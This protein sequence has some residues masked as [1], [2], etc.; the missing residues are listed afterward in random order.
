[1]FQKYHEDKI[2]KKVDI[3]FALEHKMFISELYSPWEIVKKNVFKCEMKYVCQWWN[4]INSCAKNNYIKD[5]VIF[6][7]I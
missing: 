3:L 4:F 1:M 5:N 6:A 2:L 7:F